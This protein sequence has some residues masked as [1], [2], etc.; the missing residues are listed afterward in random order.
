[1]A[2]GKSASIQISGWAGSGNRVLK[3]TVKQLSQN[4]ANNSSTIQWTLEVLNDTV[5]YD[6]YVQCWVNGKSVYDVVVKAFQGFPDRTGAIQGTETVY[7]N[8][9]GTKTLSFGIQGYVYTYSNKTTTGSLSLDTIS[10]KVPSVRATGYPDQTTASSVVVAATSDVLCNQWAYRIR[11]TGNYGDWVFKSSTSASERSTYWTLTSLTPNTTYTIQTAGRDATT[12]SWGWSNELAMKTLGP[13]NITSAA[14]ITLGRPCSIKWTPIDTTYKFRL[15]FQCG[16]TS[17]V[18]PVGG[19]YISPNTTSEYNYTSYQPPLATFASE[20][21]KSTSGSM[22]I[23]LTTYTSAGTAIGTSSKVVTCTI[24]DDSS[25]RPTLG[26]VTITNSGNTDFGSNIYVRLLS[27]VRATISGASA[28]YGATITRY[29]MSVDDDTYTST[30]GSITSSA[31]STAGSK[32]VTVSVTDSRG[33]VSSTT[34]TITVLDYFKPTGTIDYHL[35][36][37]SIDT[38]ITWRVAPVLNE[39]SRLNIVNVKIERVKISTGER[40]VK[41]VKNSTSAA[42]DFSG[43]Y[44]WT[45]A[46]QALTDADMVGYRYTLTVYDKIG[47]SFQYTATIT[48]AI[49]ALSFLRGGTGACFFGEATANGLEVKGTAHVTGDTTFDGILYARDEVFTDSNLDVGGNL[50]VSGDL[51]FG[52]AKME[53]FI[54]ETGTDSLGWRYDKYNSGKI[55]LYR[56]VNVGTPSL[57]TYGSFYYTSPYTTLPSGMLTAVN[58]VQA[59]PRSGTGLWLVS[60]KSITTSRIDYFLANSKNE[61]PDTVYVSFCVEGRWK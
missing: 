30:T 12:G 55:L 17:V 51:Y 45:A 47:T 41:T 5:Y 1:M 15:T 58:T 26:T 60:I 42:A 36:G 50:F 49:T 4:A 21:T 52:T 3:L 13:S 43:T 28:Q 7:H 25:T 16:N 10:Q 22:T 23:T 18:V 6:T 46:D 48:T 54:T 44:T 61:A 56:D 59:T 11:T 24:P 14:D 27:S 8:S 39:S 37:K 32:T 29:S 19:G 2:N 34:S 35:N 9:D 40:S 20:L 31:L 38:T 53:D 33:L 57:S